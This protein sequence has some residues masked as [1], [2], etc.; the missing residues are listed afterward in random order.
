MSKS[1]MN[2]YDTELGLYKYKGKLVIS[3]TEEEK[4]KKAKQYPSTGAIDLSKPPS[5]YFYVLTCNTEESIDAEIKRDKQI[6]KSF[7]TD[8]KTTLSPKQEKKK[9]QQDLM[10]FLSTNVNTGL[11]K[12]PLIAKFREQFPK[13]SSSQICRFINNQLKL[14]V[15]EIDKKYKTKPIVVKG[16]YWRI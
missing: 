13:L 12:K 3:K 4:K 1:W 2:E 15:I 7:V 11:K 10:N 6:K 9:R 8:K 16:K 5:K 14:K